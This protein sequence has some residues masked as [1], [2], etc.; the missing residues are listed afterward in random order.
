MDQLINGAACN[1][2]TEA[3]TGITY[4][5][6]VTDDGPQEELRVLLRLSGASNQ[7]IEMHRNPRA[8]WWLTSMQFP[9]GSVSES[10]GGV[11]VTIEAIDGQ[12]ASSGQISG[13]TFTILSCIIV[14]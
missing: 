12:G 9:Y 7:T 4:I 5:A 1:P 10:G 6:N 2:N 11:K 8:G 13:A 14:K 3:P